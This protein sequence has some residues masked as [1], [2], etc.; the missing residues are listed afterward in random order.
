[1]VINLKRCV[2]CD[3]CVVACKQENGTGPGVF[4]RKVFTTES[5][6]YPNARLN[7]LPTLCNHC[8]NPPCAAV[9]PVGAT[10]K[11]ADGVVIVDQDKCIGCRYC[12]VACPYNVRYF[13][14]SSSTEYY[15][16]KGLSPY[17]K[18]ANAKHQAG[19]VEK[20][21]FCT[22][23]LAQGLDPACVQTCPA[24]AMTFGDMDDPNSAVSK[25]IVSQNAKP[26]KPE[27]GTEPS[28]FYIQ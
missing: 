19:V 13:I 11:R 8:D 6:T 24:S 12:M 23:R 26:L 28:V 17:E 18:Q 2:G 27:A 25:I 5:G 4:W 20:C 1:M 10:S 15:P 16:G 21:T 7:Y 22:Q 3:A 9:C 14:P